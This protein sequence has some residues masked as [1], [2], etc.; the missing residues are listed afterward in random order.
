VASVDKANPTTE[1]RTWVMKRAVVLG[2]GGFLGSHLT[3]WLSRRGWTVTAVVH[4]GSDPVTQV[5]LALTGDP[6]RVIEADAGN[7]QLLRDLLR[8]TDAVFPMIGRADMFAGPEV[9]TGSVDQYVRPSMAVLDVLRELGPDGPIGVFPGSLRQYGTFRGPTRARRETDPQNPMSWYDAYKTFEESVA[10]T[11]ARLYGVRICWLRISVT[12]GPLQHISG[13]GYGVIGRFLQ[14]A[15][16]DKTIEVYGEGSQTRDFLFVDDLMALFEAAAS[17]PAAVGETFNAGGP[18][19]WSIRQAADMVVQVVGRGRVVNGAWPPDALLREIGPC[20]A[21]VEKAERLL[22]WRPSVRMADGLWRTWHRE[23]DILAGWRPP[24]T[25]S[26]GPASRHRHGRHEMS[27]KAGK[28]AE[29]NNSAQ[30]DNSAQ[31]NNSAQADNSA[32]AKEVLPE[33][34]RQIV[35]ARHRPHLPPGVTGSVLARLG[36]WCFRQWRVVVAVWVIVVVAGVMSFGPLFDSPAGYSADT[37]SSQANALLAA[38]STDGGRVIALVD[39]VDIQAPRV[40][41][42]VDRLAAD[43]STRREAVRGV[44]SPCDTRADGAPTLAYRPPGD[45]SFLVSATLTKTDDGTEAGESIDTVRDRMRVLADDL[46][47][48][49]QPQARVRVGGAP[50]LSREFNELSKKDGIRVEL[51]SLPLALIFLFFV[52]RGLL[53]GFLP[54]LTALVASASSMVVLLGLST[55]MTMSPT[56]VIVV[57]LLGLGLSIDYGLLLVARYREEVMAGF[58]PDVAASR[59]CAAAGRTIVLSAVAVSAALAGLL[60]A[61]LNELATIGAAAVSIALV[62]VVISLT[63]TSALLG[64]LRPWLT[65]PKR[66][67]RRLGNGGDRV[68]ETYFA[69]LAKSVQ[70]RPAI[71]AAATAALLLAAAAPVLGATL[72]TSGA[73]TGGPADM[74]SVQVAGQLASRF[75]TT[76]RPAVTVVARTDEATLDGWARRWTDDPAVAVVQPAQRVSPDLVAVQVDVFGEAQSEA[77][78]ELVGRI[79]AD[80]PPGVASWVTG[81]AAM[82]VDLTDRLVRNAPLAIGVTLL[83]TV[84]VLFLMTGSLLVPVKAVLINVFSLA[85]TFGIMTAVFEHGYLAGPLD[86]LQAGGLDPLILVVVLAFAFGLSMEYHLFLLGHIK[87]HVDIGFDTDAAVRHGLTNTGRIATSAAALMMIVFGCYAMGRV[88]FIEQLGFG[89]M[90]AVLVDATVVRAFL[91]PATMTLVGRWNW[92]A[93]APL[94]RLHERL[95][96][97]EGTLRDIPPRLGADERA[98]LGR[99]RQRYLSPVWKEQP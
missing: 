49:G 47:E 63:L 13:R 55:V 29:P 70:R 31:A 69:R 62:A 43:L 97:R 45:D 36:R 79:R 77:A 68:A 21:S 17:N 46:H 66:A 19:V 16:A 3:A 18:E 22:G 89:L 14:L 99:H 23:A 30:A 78:Q 93:P 96:L 83:A 40:C 33:P 71:V 57:S 85:A 94:R 60:V 50:A 92:W 1:H 25:T 91:V 61:G 59:A 76:Q 44:E 88:G 56:A 28:S 90:V 37:E 52:F 48:A 65:P 11:F 39:G 53:A 67:T 24:P 81:D 26:E 42:A 8:S 87:E 41:D 75:G 72:R 58:A 95:G 27:A 38:A 74:E 32:Q 73:A 64:A 5:R 6:V 51:L 2:A 12:Y 80:R 54:V 35:A 98:W 20:Y 86:L 4:C 7:V 84:V 15:L 34:S 9:L 82:L 10:G